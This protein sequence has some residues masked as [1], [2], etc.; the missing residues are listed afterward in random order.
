M[1]GSAQWKKKSFCLRSLITAESHQKQPQA[2]VIA[3]PRATRLPAAQ[4]HTTPRR[5]AGLRSGK[6]GARASAR[7]MR[8]TLCPA[9]RRAAQALHG[10]VGVLIHAQFMG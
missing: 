8:V 10:H 5:P 2:V 7:W 3:L 1:T 4:A 6:A 9:I